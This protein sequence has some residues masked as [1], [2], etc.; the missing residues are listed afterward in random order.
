M[1]TAAPHNRC[2]T[3]NA[4]RL[5]TERLILRGPE[6]KDAEKV[7]AFY[8]DKDRSWGF[9][10][11]I[12]RADAWRW[13]ALSVGHWSMRGYGFLTMELKET[14]EAC[15]MTGIWDPDGWPE[16]EIGWLMFDGFEGKGLAMEG[17]LR[18]R[19]WAFEDLGFTT[20][21]SNILPG[22]DRSVALAERMGA[23]FEKAYD[24]P[25]MGHDHMYRHPG[26]EA[27]T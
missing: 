14:G 25:H 5:E 6:P 3:P 19:Q 4:P 10:G 2:L 13:F 15:G 18:A 8:A 11:P 7:I 12:S 24:N 1:T 16:P 20:L 22:N 9:G 21:T 17:A 26:P 23:W 27:A